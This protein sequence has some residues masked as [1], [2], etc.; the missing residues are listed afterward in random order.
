MYYPFHG[1][2]MLTAREKDLLN[3]LLRSA[4]RKHPMTTISPFLREVAR[5]QSDMSITDMVRI[6]ATEYGCS[7]STITTYLEAHRRKETAAS[8]TSIRR[9]YAD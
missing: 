2:I 6:I 8:H 1:E 7:E 4:T 3:T 9:Q 5:T